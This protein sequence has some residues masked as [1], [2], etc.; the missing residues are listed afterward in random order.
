MYDTRSIQNCTFVTIWM[1]YRYSAKQTRFSCPVSTNSE[2]HSPLV[3]LREPRFEGNYYIIMWSTWRVIWIIG[4]NKPHYAFS[5]QGLNSKKRK[6]L[7]DYDFRVTTQARVITPD[8]PGVT[9]CIEEEWFL[10]RLVL[11]IMVIVFSVIFSYKVS[12]RLN[13]F[14]QGSDIC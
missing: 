8:L 2:T 3:P 14:A 13:L 7:A 11:I 9:L 10:S 6:R 1:C 4:E 12:R 5:P